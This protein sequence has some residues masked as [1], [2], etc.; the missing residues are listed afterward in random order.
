[1]RLR[2]RLWLRVW[3]WVRFI[4]SNSLGEA[5]VL[6]DADGG[7]GKDSDTEL[8]IELHVARPIIVVLDVADEGLALEGNLDRLVGAG[9]DDVGVG[10]VDD[11]GGVGGVLHGLRKDYDIMTLVDTDVAV[12]PNLVLHVA[13]SPRGIGRNH[14]HGELAGAVDGSGT[15]GVRVGDCEQ[16]VH[17]SGVKAGSGH[18]VGGGKFGDGVF[19]GKGDLAIDALVHCLHEDV[20]EVGEGEATVK[21]LLKPHAGSAAEG[22]HLDLDALAVEHEGLVATSVASH[23]D[24]LL[25]THTGSLGDA[26]GEHDLVALRD[27]TDVSELLVLL[28]DAGR[29]NLVNDLLDE[30][31]Q[32]VLVLAEGSPVVSEKVEL[33][34]E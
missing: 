30:G 17:G 2:L 7:V 18:G 21:E 1:M 8:A 31:E 32:G 4:S 34:A 29:D 24:E 25:G 12:A 9:V 19:E 33:V 16:L 13:G 5:G 3:A 20:G 10:R 26:T 11:L 15:T 27:G 14:G 6:V 22:A 28:K 23:G